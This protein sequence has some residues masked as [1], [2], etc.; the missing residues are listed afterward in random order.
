[1]YIYI[2]I[3]IYIYN[4]FF[5]TPIAKQVKITG[6]KWSLKTLYILFK[7]NNKRIKIFVIIIKRIFL[8][9]GSRDKK[10]FQK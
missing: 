6:K 8:V 9:F 2:Y 1:M 4:Y 10:L 3:Y 5:E 7:N